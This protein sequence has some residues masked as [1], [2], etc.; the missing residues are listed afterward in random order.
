VKTPCG[1]SLQPA[2]RSRR[3][4]GATAS[5]EGSVA[6]LPPTSA[7]DWF[8]LAGRIAFVSGSSRGI[9]FAIAQAMARA[10]ATVVLN[11]RDHSTLEEKARELAEQGLRV[12]T[13]SADMQDEKA[14][15][16]AI[17]DVVRRL[18]RIDILVNN[19]GAIHRAPL[20]ETPTDEW[21][22]VLDLNLTGAFISS[23]AAARSMT[24]AGFGRIINIASIL[25]VVGRATVT[26]YVAS[27]HGLVGLTRSIAAEFGERG[28]TCN[29]IAPGYIRTE[30]NV[31]LQNDPAFDQMVRSRTPLRRWG[32]PEDVAGAAV[33]LASGAA[34]YVNGHVL[35]V[36]GGMTSTI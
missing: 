17:D 27:K 34:G 11:G 29:A 30:I 16:S 22:R 28:I 9:G 35:V 25:A 19:A 15:L 33:F 20:Q 5:F 24:A 32:S 23:R 18:G 31:A 1:R 36:D 4:S 6:N 13:C 7:L 2:S 10:G 26:S 8:S 21:R 14:I 12:E 3:C